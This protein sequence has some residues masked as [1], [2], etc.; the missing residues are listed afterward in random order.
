VRKGRE[1]DTQKIPM[2]VTL[3]LVTPDMHASKISVI[4]HD[5]MPQREIQNIRY[6]R[7]PM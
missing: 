3:T 7:S 5:N 1:A 6:F 4:K 2:K